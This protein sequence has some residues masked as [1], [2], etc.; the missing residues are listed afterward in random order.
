MHND[1][2]LQHRLCPVSHQVVLQ[3]PLDEES[4]LKYLTLDMSQTSGFDQDKPEGLA[5]TKILVYVVLN[6]KAS[7]LFYFNSKSN[8]TMSGVVDGYTSN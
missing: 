2:S 1:N 5:K 4:Y 8:S 3:Q 7:H 6:A